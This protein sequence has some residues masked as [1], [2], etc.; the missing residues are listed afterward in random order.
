MTQ[1]RPYKPPTPD[2]LI[3]TSHER[4]DALAKRVAALEAQMRVQ[5][6]LMEDTRACLRRLLK[7]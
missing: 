1:S 3:V 7:K 5:M 2:D 6:A 4:I